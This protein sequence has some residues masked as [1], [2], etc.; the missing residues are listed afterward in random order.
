MPLMHSEDL[1]VQDASIPLFREH[2][3]P[4]TLAHALAHRDQIERFGRFP[5][6]NAALH[7]DT[8]SEEKDYM[9]NGG[10]AAAL[11]RFQP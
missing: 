2:T 8:T 1:A 10:Y 6:R 11:K 4:D 7:R 3:D 9:E 5:G